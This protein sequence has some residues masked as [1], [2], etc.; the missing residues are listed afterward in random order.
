MQCV[1]TT[2]YKETYRCGQPAG[3]S[4]LM[5]GASMGLR[6]PVQEKHPVVDAKKEHDIA[7]AG[8]GNQAFGRLL[9][10]AALLVKGLSCIISIFRGNCFCKW[11]RHL[12]SRRDTGTGV[13][14]GAR[15]R[16]RDNTA[17]YSTTDYCDDTFSSFI[18]VCPGQVNKNFRE[19]NPGSF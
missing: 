17:A 1:Q 5:S 12:P 14:G 7:P 9:F 2:G 4:R 18:P 16:R 11:F 3:L 6:F 13:A 15:V 8:Q 19:R 10:F